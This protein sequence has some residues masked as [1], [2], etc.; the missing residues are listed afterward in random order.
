[1]KRMILAFSIFAAPMSAVAEER[2]WDLLKDKHFRVAYQATVGTKWSEKW[3]ARLFGPSQETTRE[4]V[5]QVEYVF[6]DSCKPH[7]CDTN[8][9]VIAYAP[10]NKA[11]FLKLVEDGNIIWLGNP[12]PE[13]K[14]RLEN[15]YVRRFRP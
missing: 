2:A 7:Y 15:H 8:N 4:V 6:A 1:M 9:L 12:S 11:V 10:A 5:G 13:V 3:I 14:A